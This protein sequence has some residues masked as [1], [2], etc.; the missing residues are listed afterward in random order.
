MLIITEIS[1]AATAEP[2]LAPSHTAPERAKRCAP[3]RAAC[4]ARP[5]RL[6]RPVTAAAPELPADTSQLTKKQLKKLKKRLQKLHQVPAAA[7]AAGSPP[8]H[9]DQPRR[10]PHGAQQPGAPQQ[11]EGFFNVY[12]ADVS[13]RRPPLVQVCLFGGVEPA[14]YTSR[15][16]ASSMWQ[17][18]APLPPPLAARSPAAFEQLQPLY[19][20]RLGHARSLQTC[21]CPRSPSP[22]PSPPPP[23]AS[24]RA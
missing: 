3:P 5:A 1:H 4:Q 2:P 23:P 17:T 6:P 18:R 10:Q 24:G 9:G 15:G 7:A 12:G 16:A 22:S 19:A 20:C 14:G 8:G 11:Q 21:P 13:R